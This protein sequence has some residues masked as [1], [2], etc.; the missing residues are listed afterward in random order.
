MKYA[1]IILLLL[2]LVSCGSEPSSNKAQQLAE[3]LRQQAQNNTD[4]NADA[5]PVEETEPITITPE[6]ETEPVKPLEM[7]EVPKVEEEP[8]ID[9]SGMEEITTQDTTDDEGIELE[10]HERTI[11]HDFFDTFVNEITGYKFIYER[12]K[13]QVR[14]NKFKKTLAE[15]VKIRGLVI[16]GTRYNLFYYDAI[17]LNRETK[18]ATAY[19][20]GL[21]PE[22]KSQCEQLELK[23]IPYEVPFEEHNIILPEDWLL[24]NIN[25]LPKQVVKD[26]YYVNSRKTTLA[27]INTTEYYF[28]PKAGL[29]VRVDRREQ[30]ILHRYDYTELATNTVREVDIVH[31]SEDE[32][33]TEE[34]FSSR[35]D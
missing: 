31:R 16:N 26:K 2:V 18:K 13:Y 22:T 5:A 8:E 27:E 1:A 17:Y 11:M 35:I 34:V 3:E 15:P 32:V 9:T 12:D 4:V 29:P 20:E 23:D 25:K 10:E 7:P 14:S 19:C 30:G 6:P 33:P 24:N 28:D 21:H